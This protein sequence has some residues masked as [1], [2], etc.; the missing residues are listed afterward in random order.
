MGA[1]NE[2]LMFQVAIGDIR[3]QLDARKREIDKWLRENPATINVGVK[4]ELEDLKSKL[5]TLGVVFG[6][7]NKE[8]KELSSETEKALQKVSSQLGEVGNSGKSGTAKMTAG[9]R[10]LSEAMKDVSTMTER[11][12]KAS[13]EEA[14][15]RQ[16]VVAIENNILEARRRIAAIQSGKPTDFNWIKDAQATKTAQGSTKSIKDLYI[17]KLN[18]QIA[19]WLKQQ[20]QGEK[21]VT[22]AVERRAQAENQLIAAQNRANDLQQLMERVTTQQRYNNM[23]ADTE[24]LLER[25][26]AASTGVGSSSLL[27]VGLRDV[28]AFLE[29][30]SSRSSFK[31]ENVVVSNL[32]GEYNRLLKVYGAIVSE[33]ERKAKASDA[34]ARKNEQNIARENAAR[35]K[36]VEAVRA[37]ANELVR[38]RVAALQGQGASL[39]KLMSVGRDKLGTEQFDAVRN[40]LRSIREE[41]RQIDSI[42]QRGGRSIGLMLSIGGNSR[43][44]SHVIATAQ[45]VL[46]IKNQ[47]EQANRNLAASEHQVASS[48]GMATSALNGQ[49]QVLS[50]LKM[51]ATQYL[52]VWGAQSFLQSIIQTGGLLEQQ[53]LSIG[54]IL[55][56]A[57]QVT[58]LFGQIKALAVRSPFG[59][60][61]LDKMSKQL[62]AYGFEYKELF[63]WTKR[64]AD[65]SAATGTSVDRLALAL[66]HVRSEGALSGYTL[67]QFAMANVPVLRM[68]SEN[69]GISTKEV[70]EKV[71]KKDISYDDVKD[72]LKQLTDEGGMFYNAQEIMSQALN[73]KFKNL[74]DAFD[75]MYG[76]IA[77]SGVGDA[78]KRLA[79]ILTAGAKEWGRYGKD[80]LGVVAAI[81]MGKAAIYAYNVAL[82]S[83]TAATLKQA[84]ADKKRQVDMLR[85]AKEYR[86][87]TAAEWQLLATHS[88]FYATS[89]KLTVA[90][91]ALLLNEKKLSQEE[92]F[93]AVALGKINKQL[94]L[95]AALELKATTAVERHAK[96]ELLWGL[97]GVQTVSKWRLGWIQLGN[98][99]RTAGSA[100]FGF[101]KMALPLAALSLIMDRFSRVSEMKDKATEAEGDL[102]EKATSDLKVLDETFK[103]YAKEGYVK[104]VEIKTKWINGKN[105]RENGLEFNDELLSK[106]DL[107][108]DIENL[109]G[110]L[111]AMS[112]MYEG[113]LVDIDKMND[114]VEQFKALIRK[115][116]SIRHSKDYTEANAGIVT[117]T[118]VKIA[119]SN[120]FTRLFG[121][122]FTE[123]IKDYEG[124]A[125][126]VASEIN[127]LNEETI[128]KID[129][130]LQGKLTEMQEKY[131][132]DSRNSAL[133]MLFI[134]GAQKQVLEGDT[135]VEQFTKGWNNIRTGIDDSQ[136]LTLYKLF[137]SVTTGGMSR[138]LQNQFGQLASDTQEMAKKLSAIVE[139]EFSNDSDGAIYAVTTYIK[140]LLAMSGIT[141]PQAMEQITQLMLE[142]MRQYLPQTLQTSVIDEMQKRIVMEQ[143]M[144]LLG[145]SITE[146]TT[147]EEAEKALQKYSKMVIAWG[148]QMNI[149]LAKIGMDN[150]EAYRDG[151]QA[152][153]NA[154]SLK[155]DWQK[156]ASKVFVENISIKSNFDK[157]LDEFAQAVQKDLKEKQAYLKR[158]QAHL[159]MTMKID[160]DVLMDVSKL[161][162]VMDKL[163]LEGQKKAMNG[164][165][166][167]AQAIYSKIDKE[168]KPYYD[169]MVAVQ[170]DKKWLKQE[171]Y[172]ETDPNKNKGGN[173]EDKEAKRL[174]EIAKLY[175]DAYDWYKKYEKQVGEGGA[176][177]KVQ[178]QFQPLFDEFNKTWKTNLT[179]DSIPKYKA[180][181]ESL[182][183]EAMKLY[184]SP[185]HKNSYM[186]G[187]I[188]QLRDAISN[189]DY[190]EATRKQDEWASKMA[191]QLD[192]LATKWEIFNSVRESTGDTAF[193]SRVSGINPEKTGT[194]ADVKRMNISDFVGEGIKIDY[195]RVLNMSEDEI[196]KY[197]E[198]LGLTEDKLKAVINGLKDWQKTQK[199][200]DESDMINYAKFL[201]TLVD[202]QSIRQRNQDEYNKTLEETNRL[203]AENKI[204]KEEAD[205]RISVAGVTLATKNKENEAWYSNLYNNSQVMAKNEFQTS[206]NK[207]FANLN[208]QY[209]K[210][211]ITLQQY[212]E[213]VKALNKIAS[214]LEVT[215]FLGIRGGVGAFLSGGHAGLR[216]YYQGKANT[217]L[218]K[219]D[220]KEAAKYQK[221]ANKMS[222]EENATQQ[223]ISSFDQ[224]AKGANMLGDL[225]NALGNKSLG[226]A[227]ND[228]GG[229]LGGM[230]S[231]ASSFAALGPWGAAAGAGLGLI[232]GLA[233][234]HDKHREQEIQALKQNVK[235]LEANT[236]AIKM[237]RE[238]TFGYDTGQLRKEL[239]KEY[240]QYEKTFKM[241]GR[242]F[243]YNSKYGAAGLAMAEFYQQNSNGSGYKQE[244]ENLKKQR[245]DYI[246]MYNAEEDKKDSSGAALEE[247]KKKIAELDDQIH[248]FAMDL[249]NELWGIDLKGWAQQLSDALANAFENGTD[250]A[251]AYKETVTSILQSLSSKMMQMYLIEPM[252]KG[253][254]TKLFGSQRADGTYE[255][256]IFNIDD[257]VSSAKKV[258]DEIS[259]YFGKNGEGQKMITAAQQFM[260]AFEQGLNGTGLSVKN[261]S[262]NT[263]SSTIAGVS[264]ETANLLSGYVNA[265][266]QDVSINRLLLTQFITEYWSSYVDQI[267]GVQNTLNSIDYKIGVIMGL[268]SETGQL[269]AHIENMSDHLD[270]F[271]N[272][273]EKITVQ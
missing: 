200:I 195:D 208:A 192:D 63:D 199:D 61:E 45:Q 48:A 119:G 34:A 129:K 109:K 92:L 219:G 6:S 115:L 64:L 44:Y 166:E 101:A 232:S 249:A 215:G 144:K 87:L 260:T 135:A 108:S 76:E 234:L 169:A 176:L 174:R 86:A 246:D 18:G 245:Q 131:S 155:V 236:D 77:E 167:G 46:N 16:R 13:D 122:S 181:L 1:N 191:R 112:P 233:G 205:R 262:G 266:R 80:I 29:K 194:A 54:A 134:Q 265:M 133:R 153:I 241:F 173:K 220:K 251:K 39:S 247:Y 258:A 180:N 240:T 187:A 114:Q 147:P 161:R 244:Y 270:R 126:D 118:D 253:L 57:G 100:I 209:N 149:N 111:E 3:K 197:V 263:L 35:Q 188:K 145:N 30:A 237:V 202:Y 182:L 221:K 210:G 186:V 216:D 272:G 84:A 102:I 93:R 125:N 10:Q 217:A 2:R 256:G 36:S 177:T 235:A 128:D 71:R 222:E 211:L 66:G 73:A 31:D 49:S 96:A 9:A 103:E 154:V 113:D 259:S 22:E 271:A 47:T 226:G 14:E 170:E 243:T 121:D 116:E 7:T 58:E 158:N 218:E 160:T 223:V 228:A 250:M 51:L 40:A 75:I 97:R 162:Q 94:A 68:L 5:Q 85:L 268:L 26:K 143:F 242:E 89:G 248:Y 178:S 4:V 224:L 65:I 185:K 139:N 53:R 67:R 124:R 146:T 172:P 23:L 56:N 138:S 33:E 69:L 163:A 269:Y 60:V 17:E 264:E 123:D 164:D 179:L 90:Q 196:E 261:T 136:K 98:A 214:E 229:L 183:A 137:N 27:Q 204:T 41:L 91:L 28:T 140:K 20:E 107:T 152:K 83:N 257:P 15:A 50:D 267:T 213:K 37:Q 38:A 117:D 165:W 25:I 255:G 21:A 227:L 225:F 11:A 127:A 190:E 12:R 141:D 203:L 81:G 156:R 95:K 55:Q 110:T 212:A 159:K 74:H 230:V 59:V 142:T 184:Q 201:G 231:G 8:I 32:V 254:E 198:G 43:D 175:K 79:E 88:H 82:G 132:L 62:T 24:K 252:M 78:L 106:K 99:I 239:A 105:V 52:S 72:I 130:G 193:A 207:E 42:M 148:K 150:A 19:V 168:L 157:S 238:R 206:Y 273:F 151:L 189:V 104:E 70:R 120:W 171:G